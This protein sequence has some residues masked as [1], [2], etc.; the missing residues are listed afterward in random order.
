MRSGSAT[1]QQTLGT[2]TVRQLTD[3]AIVDWQKFSV[4]RN[5]LVKFVQ[6]NELAVILNRV[7][8][9]DPSVILGKLQANGQIFLVN[10]NGILFGPGSQVDVGSLVATTLA[11]RDEDFLNGN[12]RFTQDASFDL[13]SI[14]N[15]G[16]IHVSDGGYVVL[17]APLVSNE[18][19]IVANLGKVQLGAGNTFTL[20]LD[21][22]NLVSY[23]L[24]AL[25]SE[26]TVVLTPEAVSDVL[27]QVV[28]HAPGA[29]QLVEENGQV[30][31]VGGEGVLLQAGTI[32]AGGIGTDSGQL[33]VL[34]AGSTTAATDGVRILGQ[35][36]TMA[37]SLR[38]GRL[39]ETSARQTL[40]VTGDVHVEAGGEWLLDPEDLTVVGT[41][42]GGDNEILDDQINAQLDND[43]NV[44]LDAEVGT[45][46][47]TGV[48]IDNPVGGG[49]GNILV[50]SDADIHKT[51][52]TAATLTLHAGETAGKITLDGPIHSSSGSLSLVLEAGSQ[53]VEIN[54]AI[55]TAGGSLESRGGAFQ[56]TGTVELGS[57]NASLLHDSVQVADLHAG[58]VM[59]QSGN[60]VLADSVR[61]DGSLVLDAGNGAI[62][63][64]GADSTADLTG[65]DVTLTAAAGIG[66]MGTLEVD[67]STLTAQVTGPGFLDVSDPAGSMTVLSATTT[68]G[69]IHLQSA[70]GSLDLQEV[71]AGGTGRDIGITAD[72]GVRMGQV[73]AL[74]DQIVV[75][76]STG[77]IE[78]LADDPEADVV[79]SLVSL[80]AQ[81]GVGTMGTLEVE[82]DSLSVSCQLG[83]VDLA[84]LAGGLTVTS[85]VTHSARISLTVV[86]GPLTVSN[87]SGADDVT[88][89]T[90]GSGDIKVADIAAVNSIEV[91]SA[92]FLGPIIGGPS[93]ELTAPSLTLT[94]VTGISDQGDTLDIDAET[95]TFQVSGTGGVMMRDRTGD[96]TVTNSSTQ[97]GGIYL[98]CELGTLTAD[99]IS[100]GGSENFTLHTI[101]GGIRVGNVS[102]GGILTVNSSMGVEEE[103]ND[104]EADITAPSILIVAENSV[105]ASGS[106]EIDSTTGDLDVFV[107]Q[108]GSLHLH[109]VSGGLVVSEVSTVNGSVELSASGGDLRVDSLVAGGSGDV[110]LTSDGDIV[111]GQIKALGNQITLTATGQIREGTDDPD[112]DLEAGDLELT[113]GAGIPAGLEVDA[114]TASLESSG[115]AVFLKDTAGGLD[116]VGAFA[117]GDLDLT[118]VGGD[119]VAE[120]LAS[121][122]TIRLTTTT[123]GNILA[124]SVHANH[125]LVNSAQ[126]ID[127]LGSDLGPDFVADSLHVEL[128]ASGG[129]GQTAPPE[130]QAPYVYLRAAGPISA[131]LASLP[132][133]LSVETTQ[134]DVSVVDASA[135]PVVT[136]DDP[137]HRL[138]AQLPG[139]LIFQNHGNIEVDDV[140]ADS[141]SVESIGGSIVEF[142]SD[143]E[144]DITA[145]SIVLYAGSGIGQTEPLELAG[146]GPTASLNTFAG[147]S[148]ANSLV[149]LSDFQNIQVSSPSTVSITG[150][151]SVSFSGGVLN[152]ENAGGTLYFIT[153]SGNLQVADV[154]ATQVHLAVPFGGITGTI[155][156][157]SQV[158]LEA[159]DPIALT[160]ATSSL[161]AVTT[162]GGI[163]ISNDSANLAVTRLTAGN[164]GAVLLSTT[165]NLSVAS[166]S[167][168]TISLQA[169]GAITDGG[170]G[171]DLTG[172]TVSLSAGTG[173]GAT[174][175]LE[176][177]AASLTANV[178]GTGG[179]DVA[180]LSGGLTSTSV[181]TADGD[182][183]LGTPGDLEAVSILAGGSHQVSL[184]GANVK[185]G[186]IAG[187]QITIGASGALTELGSD[188]GADLT[189][190]TLLL[191]AATGIGPLQIA[192]DHLTAHVTVTGAI[193]LADSGGGLEVD[194]ATTNHG[195]ITL[196]TTGML[197]VHELSAGS[198]GDVSLSTLTSGS[199]LIDHLTAAH[200]VTVTSSGSLSELGVDSVADV[201]AG[202]NV[203]LSSPS[204]ITGLEVSALDTFA[205]VSGAGSLD[206]TSTL[207]AGR[208]TATTSNGSIGLSSGAGGFVAIANAGGSQPVTLSA[209]AGNLVI[210]GTSPGSTVTATSSGAISGGMTAG[211]LD[212]TAVSGIGNSS[213]M[214]VDVQNLSARVT[215]GGKIQVHD[216]SGG[217]QVDLATTTNGLIFLFNDGGDL[218]VVSASAG[219]S[220]FV[221]LATNFSGD[222]L[223]GS[224]SAGANEVSIETAGAIREL[225][226]DPAADLT[227]GFLDLTAQSGISPLQ[228]QAVDVD[229]EVLGA[230]SISL[231]D[232]T[233]DLLVR[234]AK[235]V[236]GDITLSTPGQMSVTTVEGGGFGTSAVS[237]TSGGDM[238]VQDVHSGH[239]I[240]LHSGGVI[241]EIV[242]DSLADVRITTFGGSLDLVAASGIGTT[243]T[244]ET[245]AGILTASVTGSGG[246][247]IFGRTEVNSLSTASGDI[248]FATDTTNLEDLVISGSLSAPGHAIT[249]S[250]GRAISVAGT[251]VSNS[252]SVSTIDGNVS[253]TN[254]N[255]DVNSLTASTGPA[256]LDFTD[257]DDLSL[258]A[259]STDDFTLKTGGNIV[260]TGALSADIF[261]L[262]TSN[263]S[264][265]LSNAGND[266]NRLQANLGTGNMTFKD[267]DELSLTSVKANNATLTVGG[268][269]R[270][271]SPGVVVQA[272]GMT[273]TAGTGIDL[274]VTIANLT[275]SVTGTG[276]LDVTDTAGGLNV[277]SA[278][279]HDGAITLLAQG[280]ALG[281]G[282]VHA[283]ISTV[284]L[285]NTGS[286]DVVLGDVRGG[287]VSV[288]SAARIQEDGDDSHPNV[289][290]SDLTLHAVSGIGVGNTVETAVT[291][292][293][294]VTN[295]GGDVALQN[296][297]S[298]PVSVDLSVTSSQGSLGYF[299]QGG[300]SVTATHASTVNG[301][302]TFQIENGDLTVV[303]AVAGGLFGG[304][305]VNLSVLL[306]GNLR[307][308]HVVSP[309]RMFVGAA[310]DI[311]EIGS[312]AAAD[313][314]APEL[315]LQGIQGIG[316]GNPL[317]IDAT[318]LVTSTVTGPLSV[319]DT[320]GGLQVDSATANDGLIRIVA[321]NGDLR[322]Q[323]A[324][325][326][327]T[328]HNVTLT[329]SGS[330]DL[331][332]GAVT[333]LDDTI[334]QTSAGRIEE[335]GSDASA[336]LTAKRINFVSQTGVGTLGT[337]E[338]DATTVSNAVV[339]QTGG[340]DLRDTAG[341]VVVT[342]AST[343]EGALKLTSDGG[344]LTLTKATAGGTGY[345][346]TGASGGDIL[347][348]QVTASGD[349]I[350]L[351]AAGAV[352]ESGNDPDPDLVATE[353]TL[354]TG[355]GVGAA[356]ATL[357]TALVR[358][359]ATVS[360]TGRILVSDQ[361]NLNVVS[362]S[363]ANGNINL[364]AHGLLTLG[365]LT[366]SSSLIGGA[367]GSIALDNLSAGDITLTAGGNI[368]ESVPDVGVDLT[369]PTLTLS[370]VTGIGAS[371]ALE[372]D[373]DRLN[374]AVS[375]TG[376]LKLVD[377]SGSGTLLT[378]NNASTNNGDLRLT[379]SGGSI[380]ANHVAAG[381]NVVLTTNTTGSVQVDEIT[382]TGAVTLNSAQNITEIG[383]D[384]EN[385]IVAGAASFL[386]AQTGVIATSDPLEV[387]ITS[388]TLSVL[389][390]A[391]IGG[392]SIKLAGS[393]TGG[394]IHL[395]TP[396]GA[397][398]FNGVPF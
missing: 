323:T 296:Q 47:P 235:T 140:L 391:Q 114:V 121:P 1:I 6:P 79:S 394:L 68:D 363:T 390:N 37:G 364:T 45:A 157:A 103:G 176:I 66:A 374:A 267:L 386:R 156:A 334:F 51:A 25:E 257:K 98:I 398:T 124:D 207:S 380:R 204:G 138:T 137:S 213:I 298:T 209:T 240:T 226:S 27:S 378:V 164:A 338:F 131:V 35:N 21:G 171:A 383:V 228:V 311:Q 16:E 227:G 221:S 304:I 397:S 369:A 206:L 355:T 69:W 264:A 81:S 392:F 200:D 148:S 53:G 214:S 105:G 134:S 58:S 278:T 20:N 256:D 270:A 52:G 112:K 309:F 29:S 187:S 153:T 287:Q 348:G 281:T 263:D 4:D 42:T 313:L 329:T 259:I 365:A 261:R 229:L 250:D 277:V 352:L 5:E 160:L 260:Q 258:G 180:D 225:G 150:E 337:L 330:G 303:D 31:L 301:N 188:A 59:I 75:S 195:S 231:A 63:E 342:N 266:V 341:G 216:L 350:H 210:G 192:A 275:A 96:L 139:T 34:S 299:Q 395:N 349:A 76:T 174:D 95:L 170:S 284:T 382:A 262:T 72:T 245:G 106:I 125:V 166:L 86:D 67:A 26:G 251:V 318:T 65:H 205:S 357:E 120:F 320:A 322:V 159:R 186:S 289:T 129:I 162:D 302:I 212:M 155:G 215:G 136:F 388:G 91:D 73:Q 167:G 41:L 336:D 274:D 325:A 347:V 315:H 285:S 249:L 353:A 241:D 389:A 196:S 393:V 113:A 32:Q 368:S 271:T 56:S 173:I 38:G 314:V 340:L 223:V 100:E 191:T 293:F 268:S 279:T 128:R 80:T 92:G 87:V 282:T 291:H 385:D 199:V 61:A 119:L 84:D 46:T 94:A 22:R 44:V 158:T 265:T 280:G 88:L 109:D 332:V 64:L 381:G 104:P 161:D 361:D 211:T 358:M 294:L 343:H 375:G 93:V 2:T 18:G 185:A 133:T 57:G 122:A 327:G 90:V 339:N 283:G 143:P 97:D 233:G 255:N 182:I 24:D 33:T 110:S 83:T 232:L 169:A 310:G 244:L 50:A 55:D 387:S 49:P 82:A 9:R 60:G 376:A 312:D 89:T 354:V 144:A 308:D 319:V 175:R 201:T 115:A 85:A 371:D 366:S 305:D 208:I 326:G 297:S 317:E 17:T 384:P 168:G 40:R 183:A 70:V 286:G 202:H 193:S 11:I 107:T 243:G 108:P 152:A 13:A 30:R 219:G 78:E 118:A 217:M 300:G 181:T 145:A 99:S 292:S 254:A 179:F 198:T 123:T 253:M 172:T 276:A 101:D 102:G 359:S 331:Y 360:G 239:T 189:A 116:V 19:M 43:V 127:E 272:T 247:D 328:G 154:D 236:N 111:V 165:G 367:N 163:S 71:V 234:F 288:T 130:I 126:F 23:R 151:D 379:A 149:L 252:L 269:L 117:G 230:G 178:S 36:L 54:S 242:P 177:D 220:G 356:G 372:I 184:N 370:A 373:A 15:Q 7:T 237:L 203:T 3:K 147:A 396:P 224:V 377:T 273:A 306:S 324:T 190:G 345:D 197:T 321:N 48:D 132:Q 362:A 333:A 248:R 346:V 10:P 39:V 77:S 194:Q 12:Y 344:T 238:L 146:L 141:A 295:D 142:G 307:V 290:A 14:V 351:T 62:E 135:N 8:G 246:I 222:V 74:D 218:A 335:L 28:R 316:L